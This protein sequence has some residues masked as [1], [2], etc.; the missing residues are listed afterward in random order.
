MKGKIIFSFLFFFF[1]FSLIYAQDDPTTI[2]PTTLDN[3]TD[4]MMGT[5]YQNLRN[6]IGTCDA[7]NA[8]SLDFMTPAILVATVMIL[9]TIFTYMIG[10]ILNSQQI[11][12]LA[13]EEIYQGGVSIFIAFIIL[14]SIS[15]SN[16]AAVSLN[17]FGYETSYI[18][19]DALDV[20]WMVTDR[21][22]MDLSAMMIF[23]GILTFF[24]AS[25]ISIGSFHSSIHISPGLALKPLTDV[26]TLVIQFLAVSLSEWLFH[27]YSLCL[28]KKYAITVFVPLGMILRA[29]PHTREGGSS[30]LA[31]M[32][33]LYLVYPVT[34]LAM[35]SIY[36]A[37]HSNLDLQE[38]SIH[39]LNKFGL[40]SGIVL[41]VFGFLAKSFLMPIIAF[42]AVDTV[43]LFIKESL[44][45]FFIMSLI[46][47]FFNIMIALTAAKEIGKHIFGIELNLSSIIRVI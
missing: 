18:I 44:F 2:D 39:L 20:A 32:L 28:I 8:L 35:G 42:G 47:P 19:D 17:L 12:Q 4:A 40:G 15:A 14:A 27:I 1:L 23:N 46:L 31:L 34:F 45:M 21:I 13:R 7:P 33:V 16:L 3:F 37:T 6:E 10:T 29:L 41:V 25:S 22:A 26:V 5:D 11:L 38:M 9:I 36:E 43:I 30:L 24:A